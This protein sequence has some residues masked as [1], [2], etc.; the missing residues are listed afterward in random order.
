M[1]HRCASFRFCLSSALAIAGLLGLT[2]PAGWAVSESEPGQEVAAETPSESPAPTASPAPTGEV[3]RSAFTS[4]IAD[5]E[6]VDQIETLG[7]DVTRVYYFTELHGLD[8][9]TVTHRWE[10]GGEV[11]AE[12][13]F[14]VGAARWRV[15]SSKNLDPGWTG[16]WTVSVLD[17]AGNTLSVDH[18]RYTKAEPEAAPATAETPP[19]EMDASPASPAAP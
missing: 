8:G 5:R 16:E 15:N 17:G 12:V 7:N 13:P 14:E 11:K 6:P 19:T 1:R 9:Q 4:A 2:A 3:T 10:Y 18:F